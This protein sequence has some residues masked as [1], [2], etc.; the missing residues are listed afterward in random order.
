[1][2]V[3]ISAAWQRIRILRGLPLIGVPNEI[4]TSFKVFSVGKKSCKC[5]YYSQGIGHEEGRISALQWQK[6]I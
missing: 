3:H 2:S 1:M 4:G 5:G 6:R